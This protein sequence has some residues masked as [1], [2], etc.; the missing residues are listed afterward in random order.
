MST[1]RA[2]KEDIWAQSS[3][4]S[5]QRSTPASP[6]KSSTPATSPS[7]SHD[8]SSVE[9][10]DGSNSTKATLSPTSNGSFSPSG[11]HSPGTARLPQMPNVSRESE[12]EDGSEDG[13]VDASDFLN[14]NDH[15]EHANAL[16]R[17]L[18]HISLHGDTTPKALKA[19]GNT[20]E[21]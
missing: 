10:N 9:T 2:R 20:A 13:N 21:N 19:A 3:S 4:A 7:K 12:Y 15:Q 8:S 1:N 17:A 6:P 16:T 18:S 14:V 5:P 11:S